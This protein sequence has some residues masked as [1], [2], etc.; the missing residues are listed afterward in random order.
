MHYRLVTAAFTGLL[1]ATPALAQETAPPKPFTVSGSVALVTDYRFRGVSQSDRDP[2]IQGGLTLG[3]ESGLYASF[4]SSNLA[5]WGTFGGPNLEL[6]L[7][8]GFKKSFGS[9][10][11]DVGL[12]WYMYPGGADKT[13]FAEPY[14]KVSGTAGPLTLLGGVAYAPQQQALGRWYY[15]GAS[16]SAGT[17]D[18]PGDKEDNL[19]LWGDA[20][21]AVPNTKLTAKAHIGYSDGNPGLGPNGTSVAPTGKYWDWL[22]GVDYA[23]Y[24]PVTIGV[25]YVDTDITNSQRAYLLPNFGVQNDGDFG[26]TIAGSKVVFSVGAAF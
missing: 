9:A 17:Y 4:W 26:K 5:G 20:A 1:F 2:A 8:G 12:T 3:H 10:T 25:A 14:V 15:S 13:D 16:A 19:Y 18:D 11:V 6:D 24:G 7:V 23:I 21:F 22:L